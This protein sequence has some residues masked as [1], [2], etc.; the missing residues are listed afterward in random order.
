MDLLADLVDASGWKLRSR[1]GVMSKSGG[2]RLTVAD[3]RAALAR[4]LVRAGTTF[5]T[6]ICEPVAVVGIGC[7]FPGM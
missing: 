5:P 4:E 6:D 2:P 7:R 3:A 1:G